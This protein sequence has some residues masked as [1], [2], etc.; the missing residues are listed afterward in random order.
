[1]PIGFRPGGASS[2]SLV[3]VDV[4]VVVVGDVNGDEMGVLL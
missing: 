3:V 4:V 1:M 2:A